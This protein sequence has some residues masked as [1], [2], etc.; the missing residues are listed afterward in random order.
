MPPPATLLD[1]SQVL[2]HAFEE[3][4]G[5]IRTTS[6]TTVVGGDMEVDITHTEDS[7]RLG[8][9]TNLT[10]ATVD[11]SDVALD[12]NPLL[13]NT[14]Q[15]INV[16][17]ALANTEYSQALPTGTKQFLIRARDTKGLL[18]LAFTSGESSTNYVEINRGASYA[19]TQILPSGTL[20][21]FFQ[22]TQAA[23]TAEILV[24]KKV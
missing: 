21:I 1:G 7:V 10:T 5:R 15:I 3:S 4:T 19:T 2:Q 9:G 11:G 23:T 13:P 24:W 12:V 6:T 18:K 14:P 22:S 20:N 8:D 17:M 16:V